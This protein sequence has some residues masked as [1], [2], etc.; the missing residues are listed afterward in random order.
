MAELYMDTLS[1]PSQALRTLL[2]ISKVEYERKDVNLAEGEH[3]Q[4]AY[5]ALHPLGT[6]PLLVEGDLKIPE[7][8]SAL[9]YV[10]EKHG[11]TDLYPKDPA[12]RAMV[13][14]ALDFSG[15]SVRQG[16]VG[17]IDQIILYVIVKIREA[18]DEEETK[19]L[20]GQAKGAM[21]KLTA[22][23]DHYGEYAALG[24]F[25]IADIQLFFEVN[26]YYVLF[27]EENMEDFPVVKAWFDRVY[28][29]A[30]VKA[31]CEEVREVGPQVLKAFGF[32]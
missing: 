13:D 21:E 14:S 3:K 6:V 17:P 26:L 15:T 29:V 12:E 23:L 31:A 19:K 16:F 24:R 20:H 22:W 5:L 10:A 8:A 11:L 4:P 27:P 1:G 30:E 9:R 32:L 25:T 28:E 18:P 7:S 2:D